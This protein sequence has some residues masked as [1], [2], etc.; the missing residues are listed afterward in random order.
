MGVDF[1]AVL[2]LQTEDHLHGREVG[3]LVALRSDQLLVGCD[4]KLCSVF[5]LEG[6]SG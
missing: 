2:L 3:R 4:G 1:L 6:V 5:E